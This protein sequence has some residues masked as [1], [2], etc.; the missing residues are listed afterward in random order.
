MHSERMVGRQ[1][2]RHE[3]EPPLP[4]QKVP[5]L[6]GPHGVV[7]IEEDAGPPHRQR[8]AERQDEGQQGARDDRDDAGPREPARVG[9][10]HRAARHGSEGG[11]V[12]RCRGGPA[13]NLGA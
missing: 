9:E 13:S 1:A 7:G 4:G 8:L 12:K 6:D 2:V 3:V 10:P 11:G 5:H